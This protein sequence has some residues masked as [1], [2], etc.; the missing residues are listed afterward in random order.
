MKSLGENIEDII[1][2]T[3]KGKGVR[4]AEHSPVWHHKAKIS[5]EDI[6]RLISGIY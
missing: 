3:V 4:E 2:R 6:N 1:A 5:I